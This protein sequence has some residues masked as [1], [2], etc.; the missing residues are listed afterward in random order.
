[1]R[2]ELKVVLTVLVAIVVV[3]LAVSYVGVDAW[4]NPPW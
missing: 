4:L 3:V 2:D 1:M